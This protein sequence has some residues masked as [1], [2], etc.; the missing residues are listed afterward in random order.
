MKIQ[1]I[2]RNLVIISCSCL[3]GCS[4]IEEE[5]VQPVHIREE[6]T[7]EENKTTPAG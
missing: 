5:I 2:L 3:F 4:T 6:W 7:Q 1:V